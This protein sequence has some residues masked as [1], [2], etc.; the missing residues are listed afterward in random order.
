M[1][2]TVTGI[3]FC[4]MHAS[5]PGV[6]IAY[7]KQ[8]GGQALLLQEAR[9]KSEDRAACEAAMRWGVTV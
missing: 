1:K 5:W 3:Y 2:C 4:N 6:A 9:L 7:F 8:Q